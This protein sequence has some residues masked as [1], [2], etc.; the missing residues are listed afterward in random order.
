MQIIS[1]TTR[2]IRAARPARNTVSLERAYAFFVE[3]ER[4]ASGTIVDVATLLL[5]NAECP[6]TCLMCD[7]WKNTLPRSAP[8]AS[9]VGQIRSALSELP[10]AREIKLYNSGNFFDPKAIP[11]YQYGE[12]A[13]LVRGFETV[14]VENHPKLCGD[15]CTEFRDLIAPS[16]LE[17]ALGLETCHPQVL[18]ALNKDMTLAD[19]ERA[20]DFLNQS[21]IRTRAFVL[22][23]PPYLSEGEGIEWA[24]RTVTFAFDRGV[25]LCAVIPTRAGNGIMEQLQLEGDFSPP[26]GTSMEEI[27]NRC[28][29]MKRGRVTIDLWDAE[30]FFSCESCREQRVQRL[31]RMNLEQTIEPSIECAE[32]R[33]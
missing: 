6:F 24:E 22:L 28:L 4:N 2:Q 17:I 11:R 1:R 20:T 31:Q 23:R 21:Q 12:I 27:L 5:T 8:E 19:F 9:I 26:T 30:R 13:D 7:L 18:P 10:P 33:S 32:C 25:S 14:I 29:E 3:K 15:A 16:K